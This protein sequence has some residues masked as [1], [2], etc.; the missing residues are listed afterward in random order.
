MNDGP[1]NDILK[2]MLDTD[3]AGVCERTLVEYKNVN[4]NLWKYEYTRKYYPNGDYVDSNTSKTFAGS[5]V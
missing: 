3:T 4:G 1:F 2:K 5:S